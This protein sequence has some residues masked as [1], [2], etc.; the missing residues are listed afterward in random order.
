MLLSE[1]H[2]E[3]FGNQL[4]VESL[5]NVLAVHLL[6]HHATTRSPLPVYEGGLPQRQLLQILDYIDTHFI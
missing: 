5:A 2:C 4:Y 1:L 6:R 3:S